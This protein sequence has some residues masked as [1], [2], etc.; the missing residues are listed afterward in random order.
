MAKKTRS[1]KGET[2]DKL[3]D[4]VYEVINDGKGEYE[5]Y[6]LDEDEPASEIVDWVSTG[7]PILDMSI[8]NRKNG[9]IPVGRVTEVTGLESSGKSLL[10]GHIIAETQKRGGIG[11]IIDTEYATDKDFL[12]AI[13]VDLSKLVYVETHLIENVF[14]IIE[15]IIATVRKTDENKLITIAVDS[16]MGA[17]DE[18]EDEADWSK[19]GFATQKARVLGKAMRKIT[20]SIANHRIALIFTNQLRV[21]LGIAFGDPYTTSGGKAIPFASSLRIRLQQLN[22]IKT[23]D[24]VAG[25]KTKCTVKK[26]RLGSMYNECTF[27]I[28]FDRGI[29]TLTTW[30]DMGKKLGLIVPGKKLEDET[31]PE[32][33]KNK[34]KVVKGWFMLAGDEEQSRFQGSSFKS[35]ILDNEVKKQ[36]LYDGICDS[37]LLKYRDPNDLE[38]IDKS[39]IVY[40]DGED[41]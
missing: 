41:D 23:K 32:G 27:D 20:S 17:S 4:K 11:V 19:A 10:I 8:S 28:Y 14:Q 37:V 6:L 15:N 12:Q 7:D 2:R 26:S 13:G 39:E 30:F 25:I 3:I 35:T 16:V 40:T 29:D 33:P 5:A 38:P 9:G 21:R 1:E 24:R 22:K 18:S 36:M 34:M 31:K